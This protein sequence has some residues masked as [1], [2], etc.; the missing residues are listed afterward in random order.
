M[1]TKDYV[2]DLLPASSDIPSYR[3]EAKS[4]KNL[5]IYIYIYIV[6]DMQVLLGIPTMTIRHSKFVLPSRR[7]L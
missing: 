3:N 5:H 2:S 4:A 1:N 7:S 6:E